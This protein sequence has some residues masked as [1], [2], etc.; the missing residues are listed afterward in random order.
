MAKKLHIANTF[1]EWELEQPLPIARTIPEILSTS[2]IYLQLQFLPF[3]YADENDAILVS[4]SPPPEYDAVRKEHG[5]PDLTVYTFDT[6]HTDADLQIDPWGHSELIARW[7]ATQ[8][9]HCPMPPWETVKTVNSKAYSFAHSKK[10]PGS[11]LLHNMTEAN[12]WLKRTEGRQR[13][14][15]TCFGVSGRGHMPIPSE[16]SSSSKK[17]DLF[18]EKEFRCNRPVIAE[19]WVD[20][21]LDFSTQWIISPQKKLD[22]VGSTLCV[23]DAKGQYR[24]NTVGSEDSVFGS[25]LPFLL[26]HK[27][28][29]QIVL[30]NMAHLGYFGHVGIDAMLYLDVE[31]RSPQLQPIVEINARKTM[32]WA[33]ILFQKKHY[34]GCCIEFQ[35]RAGS[36]GILPSKVA[37]LNGDQL[38][39]RRNINAEIKKNM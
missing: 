27:E 35:Y 15:K 36:C 8:H 32:G 6:L 13:V 21:I 3:L 38:E 20:R 23:N 14:L 12:A 28:E 25:Y 31:T 24:S 17:L 7:A 29:V 4:H 19:P 16:T 5:L 37:I 10:L 39:F 9:L 2:P 26:Q 34:P 22:Y 1:F 11:A 30:Q 18:F 33:A